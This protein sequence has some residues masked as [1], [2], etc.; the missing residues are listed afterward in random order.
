M[1]K[2]LPSV[3]FSSSRS[4]GHGAGFSRSP[5][6]CARISRSPG[7]GA[8]ISRS[9]DHG[10]RISRS[11]GHGAGMPGTAAFGVIWPISCHFMCI[12][13][14]KGKNWNKFWITGTL[15]VMTRADA[16]KDWTDCQSQS[17][18]GWRIRIETSPGS[19]NTET[20]MG[21]ITKKWVVHRWG[22][23]QRLKWLSISNLNQGCVELTTTWKW[24]SLPCRSACHAGQLGVLGGEYSNY[25]LYLLF[26][27]C[28]YC[29][30]K[31]GELAMPVSLV[32]WVV[33]ISAIFISWETK[34]QTD[35]HN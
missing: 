11:P 18:L 20:L 34:I 5:N 7:H 22:C 4:R 29:S 27:Y 30:D 15:M 23:C 13:V 31:A 32:Y 3:C 10:A 2:C 26:Y 17:R 24:A 8:G 16:V 33:S 6:H 9:P 25:L 28:S 14:V 21:M 1:V 19:L 35:P 12:H